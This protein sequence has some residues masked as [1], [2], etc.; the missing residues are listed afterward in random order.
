MD[1]KAITFEEDD[2]KDDNFMVIVPKNVEQ[3]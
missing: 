3:E 1:R 2:D